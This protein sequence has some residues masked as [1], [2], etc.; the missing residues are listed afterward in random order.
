MAD[1]RTAASAILL[2]A[3]SSNATLVPASGI[4]VANTAGAV[5]LVVNPAAAQTGT[6]TITVTLT[7]GDGSAAT[8]TFLLTVNA[9]ASNTLTEGFESGTKT[10]YAVGNVTFPSGI[11]TL[12]DALVG[13]SASDQK[14]GL[15]SL[16]VRNGKVTMTFNWPN[17][18]QTVTVKHAKYGTDA[19]S[20]WELWYSTNSGTSWTI[21]GPAVVSNSTT[22][23]TASFPVNVTGPIRFE[24]R[25]TIGGTTRFN[26]DD[27][28]ITGF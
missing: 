20:T 6:A 5:T 24:F 27:F 28:Q 23:A 16:R 18:A 1:D 3:A 21:A 9:G 4:S 12:D 25:K 14:T 10:A 15:Q 8:R 22:L 7:D 11:W 2:A 17:G 19:D 26:L 13:N